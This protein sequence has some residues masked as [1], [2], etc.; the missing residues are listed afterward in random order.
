MI[1]CPSCG[2]QNADGNSHCIRCGMALSSAPGSQPY[3]QAQ[4]QQQQPWNPPYGQQPYNPPY[5][6]PY[7]PQQ[8]GTP[9]D[10]GFLLLAL[11]PVA[12]SLL[13]LLGSS[14]G[15]FSI[16]RILTLLIGA[17]GWVVMIMYTRNPTYRTII[18][19]IAVLM[20]AWSVWGGFRY[21]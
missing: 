17:A 7:N 2:N 9:Q 5:N 13:W 12:E 18:I 6:Q 16:M 11:I 21:F 14:V 10:L 8:Q 20:T 15:G 4:Q 3:F 1:T 19:V